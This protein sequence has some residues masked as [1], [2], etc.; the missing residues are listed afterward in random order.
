MPPQIMY[1]SNIIIR[2]LPIVICKTNIST[3]NSAT[4]KKSLYR[5]NAMLEFSE[6]RI[7]KTMEKYCEYQKENR[8]R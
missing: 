2:R 8:L 7:T 6:Q 4:L 1:Q 5:R 3:Q